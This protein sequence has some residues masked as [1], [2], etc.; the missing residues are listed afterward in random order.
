[1]EGCRESPGIAANAGDE[2]AECYQSPNLIR[3]D[4]REVCADPRVRAWLGAMDIN[5]SDADIMFGLESTNLSRDNL[6]R[7]IGRIPS[8]RETLPGLL[9]PLALP[10]P[11]WPPGLVDDG[12]NRLSAEALHPEVARRATRGGLARSELVHTR[13]AHYMETWT[14]RFR[15]TWIAHR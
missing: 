7:E 10:P 4:P 15:D 1:M 11:L 2:I 12:D 14:H 13:K 6:S 5:F 8:S 9:A 3:R